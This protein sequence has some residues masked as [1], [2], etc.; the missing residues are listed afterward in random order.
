M[1]GW[2]RGFVEV[3]DTRGDILFQ[4]TVERCTATW[5]R[6]K[7]TGADEDCVASAVTLLQTS[8]IFTL[9]IISQQ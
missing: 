8:G 3:Y 1:T 4:V 2:V 6:C 5:D 9:V 7:V